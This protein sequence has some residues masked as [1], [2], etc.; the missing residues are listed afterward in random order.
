MRLLILQEG[1]CVLEDANQLR[2]VF[3]AGAPEQ[4]DGGFDA[5]VVVGA[6]DLRDLALDRVLEGEERLRIWRGQ[7]ST[8]SSSPMIRTESATVS[9]VSKAMDEANR[10]HSANKAEPPRINVADAG[11]VLV[12]AA[13]LRTGAAHCARPRSRRPDGRSLPTDRDAKVRMRYTAQGP[14]GALDRPAPWGTGCG[15]LSTLK[16]AQGGAVSADGRACLHLANYFTIATRP[17]HDRTVGS[18]RVARQFP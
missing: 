16:G 17:R 5:L 10:S 15:E 14:E 9:A 18:A 6:E 4:A 12:G 11:S 7:R 1:Q 13:P 3:L 2:Q 8:T